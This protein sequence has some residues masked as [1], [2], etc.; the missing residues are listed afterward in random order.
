MYDNF[1]VSL[2][3]Q[4]KDW[5]QACTLLKTGASGCYGNHKR[6]WGECYPILKRIQQCIKG[7]QWNIWKV[8]TYWMG[9]GHGS[10]KL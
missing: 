4:Q 1:I 5:M 6:R 10:N 7:C 8:K 9:D 2:V 3:R